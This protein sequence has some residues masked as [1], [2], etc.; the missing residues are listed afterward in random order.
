MNFRNN[1]KKIQIMY[2]HAYSDLSGSSTSLYNLVKY[3]DKSKYQITVVL[4]HHSELAVKLREAGVHVIFKKLRRLRDSRNPLPNIAFLLAFLPTELALARLAH[5]K[6]MDIIHINTMLNFHGV[7]AAKLIGVKLV[8]HI[9][10]IFLPRF[11]LK[12]LG[13]FIRSIATQ[14]ITASNAAKGQVFGRT[15]RKI[16]TIHDAVNP[17]EFSP[18]GNL[19]K[20]KV[21]LGFPRHLCLVGLVAALKPVKGHEYFIRAA[22][23][24]LQNIKNV[25]FI[26][27]GGSIKGRE[28]YEQSILELVSQLGITS[29]VI[30]LGERRDVP[31]IMRALDIC[32]LSSIS[33]GGLSVAVLEAMASGKPVIATDAGGVAEAVV[34]GVTGFVVPPQEPSSLAERILELIEHPKKAQEMGKAGRNRVIEY[35]GIHNHAKHIDKIYTSLLR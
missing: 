17:E 25:K 28:D 10:E 30:F 19:Q 16:V 21:R 35:F 27:V 22:S 29:D 26:I 4:P 9:R 31:Q 14:V 32:V 20:T 5:Q 6:E 15:T 2:V 34:D 23:I 18:N 3:L 7:L 12:L 11:A 24:V 1:M 8:W 13:I 33:E